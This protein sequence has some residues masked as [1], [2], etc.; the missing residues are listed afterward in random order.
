MGGAPGS[1]GLSEI[2]AVIERRDAADDPSDELVW[3]PVEATRVHLFQDPSAPGKWEGDVTFTGPLVPKLHRLV[4]KEFEWFRTDDA[5]SS[6]DRSIRGGP[7]SAI[8]VARRIV[9]ADVFAI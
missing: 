6:P 1:N 2:E 7:S 4:I 5:V 3:K 9:F 8:R